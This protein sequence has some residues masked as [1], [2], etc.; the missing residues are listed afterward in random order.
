M[1]RSLVPAGTIQRH[2][3]TQAGN[4]AS[5]LTA[6]IF[7]AANT[8]ASAHV[9]LFRACDD[10]VVAERSLTIAANST[11]SVS[12]PIAIDC[13]SPARSV[14]ASGFDGYTTV[15]VDQPS[16]SMVLATADVA[17]PAN[18]V[19]VGVIVAAPPVARTRAV[20]R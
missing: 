3:G 14:I 4:R 18:D 10:T 2:L 15:T 16:L 13:S 5:T 17:A 1:F 12:L 9:Q 6:V 11:D 8:P 19:T 7:N 20:R